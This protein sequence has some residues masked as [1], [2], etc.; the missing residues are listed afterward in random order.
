MTFT[1]LPGSSCGDS[2]LK[3]MLKSSP[4][5][6][7][8]DSRVCLEQFPNSG[9]WMWALEIRCS[10]SSPAVISPSPFFSVTQTETPVLRTKAVSITRGRLSR[11]PNSFL[12]AG[13]DLHQPELCIPWTNYDV[14]VLYVINSNNNDGVIFLKKLKEKRTSTVNA[15]NNIQTFH[16]QPPTM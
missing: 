8:L 12:A 7:S 5:L 11:L 16:A 13:V 4:R 14:T 2:V 3:T 1:S 10:F 15:C 6:L 9:M